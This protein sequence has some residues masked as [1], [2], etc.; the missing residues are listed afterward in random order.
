MSFTMTPYCPLMTTEGNKAVLA[1]SILLHAQQNI[2]QSSRVGLQ[3]V[4]NLWDWDLNTLCVQIRQI[5]HSLVVTFSLGGKN[6]FPSWLFLTVHHLT[7]F[8]ISRCP[9]PHGPFKHTEVLWLTGNSWKAFEL[10]RNSVIWIFLNSLKPICRIPC[11]WELL[12]WLPR[13]PVPGWGT[14]L[15]DMP[16]K[17]AWGTHSKST[18]T[19]RNQ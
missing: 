11:Q 19:W 7:I 9:Q 2:P 12:C 4:G 16:S 15:E 14:F 6:I 8:C 13:L 3:H 18:L 1:F 5:R 17:W 10:T